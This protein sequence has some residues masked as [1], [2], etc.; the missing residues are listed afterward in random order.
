MLLLSSCSDAELAA[1][2]VK[3]DG[4]AFAELAERYDWLIGWITR[5]PIPGLE[6]EDEHQ[7]ALIG[8]LTACRDYDPARGSFGAIATIRQ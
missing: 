2:V 6:R 5:R 7:E 8:L 3:G 4:D 1:R